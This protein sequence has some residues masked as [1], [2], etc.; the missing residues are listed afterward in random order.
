MNKVTKWL[1]SALCALAFTV[2]VAKAENLN[3]W[4]FALGGAGATTTSGDSQTAFGVDLAVG[5]T[6]KILL[7]VEFGVRQGIAYNTETDNGVFD[8]RLFADFT[9]FSVSAVD[10]FAGANAGLTYGDVSATWTVAPE[11]GLRFFLK[12]DVAVVGRV[13]YPYDITNSR[14]QNTLRYTVGLRVNF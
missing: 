13:E 5:R 8:T 12:D 2:P 10:V 3:T 7:P 1:V 9:L 4:T 6:G 14:W 11:A